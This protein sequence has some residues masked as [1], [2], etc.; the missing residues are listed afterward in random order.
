MTFSIT[1]H[2]F[3]QLC[4]FIF[5]T[6]S[7]CHLHSIEHSG[8]HFIGPGKV[9]SSTDVIQMFHFK[10]HWNINILY[11][12]RHPKT[13]P[14]TTS[15]LRNIQLSFEMYLSKLLHKDS[16]FPCT[17]PSIFIPQTIE[18]YNFFPRYKKSSIKH[19]LKISLPMPLVS[20][21]IECPYLGVP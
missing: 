21:S 15:W 17:I 2:Y 18:N 9:Y 4:Y 1:L 10:T 5:H 14:L 19:Y 7:V 16:L 3:L 8:T 12:K 6:L 13:F 11:L 20:Y